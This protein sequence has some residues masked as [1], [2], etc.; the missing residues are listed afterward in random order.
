MLG[1]YDSSRRLY[2]TFDPVGTLPIVGSG[3]MMTDAATVA[4]FA[5][6]MNNSGMVDITN[7]ASVAGAAAYYSLPPEYSFE[8]KFLADIVVV[9]A[10]GSRLRPYHWQYIKGKL[11]AAWNFITRKNQYGKYSF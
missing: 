3:P 1:R 7:A 5:D 11:V 6:M 9:A 4:M 8:P 10:V 2:V